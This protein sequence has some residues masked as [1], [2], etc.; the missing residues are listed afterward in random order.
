MRRVAGA[1]QGVSRGAIGEANLARSTIST[2]GEEVGTIADGY[3][4][5][6]NTVD[7]NYCTY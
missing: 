3:N 5:P 7:I 4:S 2:Y 6:A 1:M